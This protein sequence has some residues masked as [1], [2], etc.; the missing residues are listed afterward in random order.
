M[1]R[2]AF[3]LFL[4]AII[5]TGI[6]FLLGYFFFPGNGNLQG[7]RLLWSAPCDTFNPAEKKALSFLAEEM[8]VGEPPPEVDDIQFPSTIA[9]LMMD[10]LITGEEALDYARRIHGEDNP[11][12]RVFIS[13]YSGKH[14]Q[15]I[16]WLFEFPTSEEALEYMKKVNNRINKSRI[17]QK[18]GFF[19]LQNV[20]INYVQGLQLN[21]N[22]YYNKQKII[23]WISLL[24]NDPIP[25]FLK[26]YEYF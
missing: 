2:Q 26:F 7:K 20:K 12:Q 17:C 11:I 9:G 23:Y 10:K 24:N 16:L 3:K 15:V 25:L 8:F 14:E 5:F 22:Y 4:L 19:Y 21:N 13:H 6:G 18:C 1:Y